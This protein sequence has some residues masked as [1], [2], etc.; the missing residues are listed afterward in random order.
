MFVSE[1]GC[2]KTSIASFVA[3]SLKKSFVVVNCAT[4]KDTEDFFKIINEHFFTK[5]FNSNGIAFEKRPSPATIIMDEASE[6][7][8]D[9]TMA[10]LTILNPNSEGKNVFWFNGKEYVFDFSKYSFFF[11]TT[12]PQK[13]FHALMDRCERVDLEPYTMEDLGKIVQKNVPV[14]IQRKALIQIASVLRGNPRAAQKMADTINNFVLNNKLSQFDSDNWQNLVNI[15]GI[16]PLGV[17]N[18]EF[19]IL[20]VLQENTVVKLG[21]LAAKLGLTATSIQKHFEHFL[22]RNRLI[23]ITTDGRSLT[24]DGRAYIGSV[25]I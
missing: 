3:K 20:K 7:P 19:Q 9:L 2:G 24:E 4:L 11:A 5:P 18:T 12:E 23:Q 22:V 13:V 25:S 21:Q 17:N 6:L 10:L 1:K 16:L 15:L 8:K 14:T